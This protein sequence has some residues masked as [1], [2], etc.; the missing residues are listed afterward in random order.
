LISASA[1]PH[2]TGGRVVYAD[3]KDHMIYVYYRTEAVNQT[4][5]ADIALA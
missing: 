4:D 3:R 1:H 2:F 5:T